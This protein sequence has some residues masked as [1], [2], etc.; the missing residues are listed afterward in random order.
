MDKAELRDL[1]KNKRSSINLEKDKQRTKDTKAVVKTGY[2]KKGDII[3]KI[4]PAV[5]G[6]DGK[7]IL[8]DIIHA[9]KVKEPRLVTLENVK[10]EHGV[11]YIM[12]TD[13]IVELLK[14]DEDIFYIRG[15]R[16]SHGE[17]KIYMSDDEMKAF[18]TVIPPIGGG[19][20]VSLEDVLS[21]CK[22]EN[23]IYGLKKDVIKKTIEE[24]TRDRTIINDV[25]IA[26]GEDAIDGED[27]IIEFM[28]K[29]ASGERFKKMEDGKVDFKEHDIIINVEKDQLLATVTK[30]EKGVKD[31]HTVKGEL[32]QAK[33]G[34]DIK[35]E[36]INNIRVEDDGSKIYYYS[37]IDGQLLT[38]KKNISVEPMI[39]INSDV[40][41]KTGNIRFNG[42]VFIKGSINDNYSVYARE[43]ITVNGNVG[44]VVLKSNKNII[45]KNGIVGKG[46]GIIYAKGDVIVKFA[47]NSNIRADGNIY[48]QRAALNCKL[49]AGNKIISKTEKG[50]IIGGELRAKNGIEVKVLGNDSEHKMDIYTGVDFVIEEKLKELKSRIQKYETA[51]E[52]LVLVL[53]K[54][55][56]V[57]ADP[58]W[59]T[60]DLKKIYM[61]TSKKRMF[62]KIEIANLKKREA[63]YLIRLDE[64][65]DSEVVVYDKLYPG[66]KMY[67]GNNLYE[68]K[69]MKSGIRVFYDSY[70]RKIKIGAA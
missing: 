10:V 68:T 32:I 70:L 36:V 8:G 26:E 15:K 34:H 62:I 14:N 47:E 48:I 20:S 52:K 28:I 61:D 54:L 4:K 21:Y 17:F 5:H 24:V 44:S 22:K 3:A 2:A 67:F 49:I 35:L 58:E 69:V 56:K 66:V 50:Q 16:Y 23:I 41:P 39:T 42:I 1:L 53:G 51:L 25:L 27:G 11:N 13:G 38:D 45:V 64:V 12:I 29:L 37:V 60:D 31:G 46:K 6:K 30:G 55:N 65:S 9:K 7:N 40:G 57:E 63:E 33:N 18:I 43:N 19:R 59:L